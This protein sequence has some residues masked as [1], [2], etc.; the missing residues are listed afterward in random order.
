MCDGSG[1]LRGWREKAAQVRSRK[2]GAKFTSP[3]PAAAL[4]PTSAT[5]PIELPNTASMF[6]TSI[7]RKTL[8]T[9]LGK[10]VINENG[11]E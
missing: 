3:A 6:T 8:Q 7:T 2:A 9:R 10:I 4:A 1:L 5:Q 11:A